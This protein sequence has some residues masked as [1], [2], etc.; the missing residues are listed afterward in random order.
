VTLQKSFIKLKE[1]ALGPKYEVVIEQDRDT[2]REMKQ[3]LA[4]AEKQLQQAETFSSQR[5]EEKREVE[6]LRRKIEQTDAD[7]EAIHD[8]QGSNLESGAELRRLQ[9]LK[10]NYQTDLE[11]KKKELDS[12]TKKQET[13]K[14]NKPRLTDSGPASLQKKVKQTPW[15]KGTTKQNL[16][17][18]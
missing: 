12:L 3:R 6:V 7:I 15:K 9:Q 10:K 4:E 5:E 18:T 1:T 13:E 17:T 16:W 11:N 8:E 14:K 2:I